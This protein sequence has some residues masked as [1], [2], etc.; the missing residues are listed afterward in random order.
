MSRELEILADF[1]V[2]KGM[3]TNLVIARFKRARKKRA[4]F[5]ESYAANSYSPI[6]D[7]G[8]NSIEKQMTAT[9]EVSDKQKELE[10]FRKK[11]N[12]KNREREEKVKQEPIE[13]LKT[14]KQP[15]LP[16]SLKNKIIK[17]KQH[18]NDSEESPII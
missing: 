16:I 7:S 15:I 1:G 11:F 17:T 6:Q 13:K 10:N 2:S 14:I 12:L 3:Y 5:A 8:A 4:E 18:L 9:N